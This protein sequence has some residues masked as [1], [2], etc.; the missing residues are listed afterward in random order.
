MATAPV[1]NTDELNN[2]LRYIREGGTEAL[3][4]LDA[5]L[6][7]EAT[8][9]A[10]G[11]MFPQGGKGIATGLGKTA[12]YI[13]G[14]G[15]EGGAHVKRMAMGA[16]KNPL[17]QQG[18]KYA[19]VVGAGLAVGDLVLGDESFGNKAMDAA[20]MGVGGLIGSAVPV[21]GTSLGIAGGKLTSDA[22]QYLFGGGV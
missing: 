11:G 2:L 14:V 10:R 15:G 12:S 17:L 6:G 9:A 1:T 8:H 4:N 3:A 19:P 22:I 20:A 13:P 5:L 16:I 7:L 21:V 18:L